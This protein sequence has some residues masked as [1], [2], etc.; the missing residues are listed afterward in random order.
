MMGRQ[1]S[2]WL[3]GLLLLL[4][5]CL[6]MAASAAELPLDELMREQPERFIVLAVAN[7]TEH[8]AI[9]PGATAGGYGMAP[10]YAGSAR[11]RAMMADLEKEYGLREAGQWLIA[12]LKLYCVV[13]LIPE[14]AQREVL[15]ASLQKD[16]RVKLVQPL[17]SFGTLSGAY[18]DPYFSLQKGFA[19]LDGGG[20][21]RLSRGRGVRL[22]VID[23][24]VD[25][26]HP[27][28]QGS[29]ISAQNFVDQNAERFNRDR[30]GTEVAGIVAA[31]ANNGEGIAGMA[32]AVQLMALKACWQAQG[33]AQCNSFT[34]A[35]A[36]LDAVKNGA[37]IIN[38][39][40]GGPSDGLLSE[41]IAHAVKQG[42]IVV[43]AM[44]ANGR[45]GGFPTGLPGVI[46]VDMADRK[47]AEPGILYAPGRETLTLVP[48]GHYDFDSGSSL[49]TAYVSASIALLLAIDPRLDA[50]AAFAL[51]RR[52]SS[53]QTYQS[54]AINACAALAALSQ[55]SGAAPSPCRSL[56]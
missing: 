16:E 9:H 20:A 13:V 29:S 24:G 5:V 19:E 45:L 6:S 8:L 23:T 31:V 47:P 2:H 51:L 44:P 46:A 32:P 50:K 25:L 28:F 53:T 56:D 18:N 40:L 3:T 54:G 11:A 41:L 30:H 33:G 48:G 26:K 12:P 42:V 14:A 21:H 22:A 34:L 52:T 7:P 17:Q 43:A 15:I 55:P 4:A 27:D 10:R 49:A 38:L 39:S 1:L 36:L 37:Q 35:Q